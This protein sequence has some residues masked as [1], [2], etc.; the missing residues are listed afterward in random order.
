MRLDPC[1][2]GETNRNKPKQTE[3]DF[4]RMFE[5]N[6]NPGRIRLNQTKY[7]VL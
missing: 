7:A 4:F 2:P 3:L 6:A 5:K 1:K